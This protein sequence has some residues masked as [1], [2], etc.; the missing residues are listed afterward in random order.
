MNAHNEEITPIKESNA[1]G[2]RK[3]SDEDIEIQEIRVKR[4]DY[5]MQ[6]AFFVPPSLVTLL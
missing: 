1:Y 6:I 3:M 5:P 4:E 2:K